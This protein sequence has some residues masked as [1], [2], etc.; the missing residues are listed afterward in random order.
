[1]KILRRIDPTGQNFRSAIRG[2]IAVVLSYF[3]GIMFSP[4]LGFLGGIVAL[5]TSV[6][7]LDAS[8]ETQKKTTLLKIPLALISLTAGILLSSHHEVQLL[9]FVVATFLALYLR[10][11][12][13]RWIAL[14]MIIFMSYFLPLFFPL[15]KVS[16]FHVYVTSIFA[17]LSVFILRYFIFPDRN[18]KTLRILLREWNAEYH[19][20][21]PDFDRMNE[22]TL[23]IENL[24]KDRSE[25]FHIELFERETDLRYRGKKLSSLLELEKFPVKATLVSPA[26][27]ASAATGLLP[28]TKLAIQGTV[29]VAFASWLGTLV[30]TERWYWASIAAFVILAGTSRGETLVRA[31]LRVLGT[32]IGLVTGMIIAPLIAGHVAFEWGLI[33]LSIFFGIFSS[34]FSFGFWSATVFTFMLTVLFNVMG[35]YTNSVLLLRFEE[36]LLGAAIGV[37]VSFLVL[38][39][40]TKKVIRDA[41]TKTLRAQENVVALLPLIDP[42]LTEKR[43]LVLM[44]RAMERELS[45][46]KTLSVPYTGRFSLIKNR[47][48]VE[49]FHHVTLLGHYIK[50]LATK[51]DSP[52]AADRLRDIRSLLSTVNGDPTKLGVAM[53]QV[54]HEQN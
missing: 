13:L 53:A 4:I 10:R 40:S 37:I 7:D 44:V 39:T 32:I 42:A 6:L 17:V 22:L 33:I 21:S 46:L 50:D 25:E 48:V 34:K 16:L 8:P 38:P 14:G 49:E 43:T 29:A 1:M 35:Q 23:Q 2:T 11:W 3:A 45:T 47:S 28:T 27:E 54:I 18:E 26:P 51:K 19:S 5:L 24:A 9:I 12:G 30:S 52:E 41:L 15:D 31:T 20:L 36:T